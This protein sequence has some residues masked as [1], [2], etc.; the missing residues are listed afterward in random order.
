MRVE[1]F[2]THK[3]FVQYVFPNDADKIGNT[4]LIVID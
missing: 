3:Q 2:K 4:D 1:V